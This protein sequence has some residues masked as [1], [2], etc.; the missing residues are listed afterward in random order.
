M[1]TRAGVSRAGVD[2]PL[3]PYVIRLEAVVQLQAHTREE[4]ERLALSFIDASRREY[5]RASAQV[6]LELLPPLHP[7][8]MPEGASAQEQRAALRAHECAAAGR[9]PDPYE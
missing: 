4:A 1:T 2:M 6:T 5:F 9:G 7:D 3:R 8:D